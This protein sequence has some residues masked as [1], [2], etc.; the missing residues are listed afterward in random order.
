[1]KNQ[2]N[3]NGLRKKGTQLLTIIAI[4]YGGAVIAVEASDLARK[5][6]VRADELTSNNI[7]RAELGINPT[8]ASQIEYFDYARNEKLKEETPTLAEFIEKNTTSTADEKA[9][10]IVAN[11]GSLLDLM[12][13]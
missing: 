9:L 13:A 3:A 12:M 6:E 4:T 5:A 11:G 10:E 1:M 8:L 7:A 2:T